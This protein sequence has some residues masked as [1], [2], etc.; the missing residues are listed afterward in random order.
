MKAEVD[1]SLDLK[2]CKTVSGIVPPK[3]GRIKE[4]K[5]LVLQGRSGFSHM[6]IPDAHYNFKSVP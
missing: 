1:V 4:S 2:P 6:L 5:P 3:A